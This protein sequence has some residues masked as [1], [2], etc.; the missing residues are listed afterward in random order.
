MW[1]KGGLGFLWVFSR[2]CETTKNATDLHLTCHRGE[3]LLLVFSNTFQ[4][5]VEH[6]SPWFIIYIIVYGPCSYELIDERDVVGW[7]ED[8]TNKV[9][10]PWGFTR[11]VESSSHQEHW[12][13]TNPWTRSSLSAP[14]M[15]SIP[16]IMS[17]PKD[18]NW[19]YQYLP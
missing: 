7:K 8:C 1:K 6:E 14:K 2:S 5:G 17:Q 12:T 13:L 4:E 16:I 19:S 9:K 15:A 3:T 10:P 11:L 18:K